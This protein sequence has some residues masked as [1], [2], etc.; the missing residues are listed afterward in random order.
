MAKEKTKDIKKEI[1]KDPNKNLK[2]GMKSLAE[3]LKHRLAGVAGDSIKEPEE[4]GETEDL[5]KE[6]QEASEKITKEEIEKEAKEIKKQKEGE[7]LIPLEDYI[8]CAVHLGT[9]VITPHMRKFVYKRRAD[10][11]AVINTVAIDEKLREAVKFL[12]DYNP[13]QVYLVCRR[14]AGWKSAEKF[15]EVTGIKTFTKKYPPGITTNLILENFFEAELTI[16]CDPWM[17]RNAMLDT[18]RLKKP[19]LGLCCTNNFIQHVTKLIPCNNKATKSIGCVL[20]ILARE[21]CKAKKIPFN[22][23]L[24]DFTGPLEGN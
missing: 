6:I 12:V 1:K 20:F 10:G 8:K 17:D 2:E 7:T 5:D 14:E 23:K 9:K 18:Y 24:E 19:V 22:A 21:Y 15:G 11:L 13:E 3:E 16:I 4:A